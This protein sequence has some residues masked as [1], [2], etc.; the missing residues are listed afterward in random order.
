MKG[1]L[2]RA[3]LATATLASALM[4]ASPSPA[5]ADCEQPTVHALIT[6]EAAVTR[7]ALAA[8]SEMPLSNIYSL[9]EQATRPLFTYA[10]AGP[11]YAG[12][13]EALLPTSLPPLPRSVSAHPSTD[14]PD[15]HT[16]DWGGQS[17]TAVTP[18]SASATS[19]GGRSLGVGGITAETVRSWV[20][21]TVECDVVTVIA[22]WALSEVALAPG[23]TV[24]Q[25]GERVTLVVGPEGSSADVE[26]TLVGVEGVPIPDLDGRLTDG[27][28]DPITENG[29]PVLEVGEPR[30]EADEDGASA[31]GG[32]FNFL[33]T[34]PA[35]GQG[36]GFRIGS[37]NVS[38]EVLGAL[39]PR[40]SSSVAEDS[41]P[42]EGGG[43]LAGIPPSIDPPANVAP[44]STSGTPPEP[45]AAALEV[46]RVSV[47]NT[48][49]SSVEVTTR[50]WYPVVLA[51]AVLLA[52]GATVG[53]GRLSRK[54]FPTLDWLFV[55]SD[56][57]ILRFLAVYLRW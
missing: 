16:E 12:A 26:T 27:V 21:S 14:I 4:V 41:N 51:T 11:Q 1:R 44:H 47:T 10:E 13:I 48:V 54:R 2:V 5:G 6:A 32:G 37:V 53:V 9:L 36:A 49:L 30:T 55:K 45:S 39:T 35:T 43:A 18:T 8:G 15:E 23:L 28:T 20:T 33:L 29:G 24:E 50:S 22:G 17:M 31:S 7:P 19:I 25:I 38:I 3:V 34:D 57:R 56:R 40:D 52:L 46:E 42:F